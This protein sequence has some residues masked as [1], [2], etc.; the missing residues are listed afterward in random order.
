MKITHSVLQSIYFNE[1]D[2]RTSII[3]KIQINMGVYV[4]FCAMVAY[5][6][7]MVDYSSNVYAILAFYFFVIL[8][9]ILSIVSV[10]HAWKAF[11]GFEYR[12]FPK[13]VSTLSYYSELK[14]HK[15]ELETYNSEYSLNENVPDPDER[16]DMFTLNW[17]SQ[18]IDH[19]FGINDFRRI[20][21]KR[22][23]KWLAFSAIPLAMASMIFVTVDLDVSSP[24]KHTL[25]QDDGV[26]TEIKKLSEHFSK[27]LDNQQ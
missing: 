20:S 19:N 9:L 17:L 26:R 13:A 12:V 10:F 2:G 22:S 23:I 8:F 21:T 18:C 14:K 5:M 11:V 3:S 1:L 27:Q 15:V 4:T 6:I 7:R 16:I 25:I 24:R